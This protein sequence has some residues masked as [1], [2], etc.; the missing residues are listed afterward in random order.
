MRRTV[1]VVGAGA[2]SEFRLPLGTS[3]AEA[4]RISLDKDFGRDNRQDGTVAHA[5]ML[6][7]LRGEDIEGA[8]DL[9]GTLLNSPSIDHALNT[10]RDRP[11]VVR[12]G[13]VAIADQISLGE[14]GS[15]LPNGFTND[16]HLIHDCLAGSRHTWLAKLLRLILADRQ[17]EEYVDAFDDV[18]FV[19]FNYDRC[20]EQYLFY[21]MREIGNLSTQQAQAIIRE[22]PIVHVYGSL[23]L[24][25]C[26]GGQPYTDFGENDAHAVAAMSAGIKTYKEGA[27]NG[28][29]NAVREM[30]AAAEQVVFL[31]FGFDPTNVEVLYPD[32]GFSGQLVTG[33]MKVPRQVDTAFNEKLFG[34]RPP[35][36]TYAF[37]E[38]NC[39]EY[40]ETFG[41]GL[42]AD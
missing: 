31:G 40:I 2:S 13:K 22:I 33:T 38:V 1:F 8:R 32:G 7:V 11:S 29:L 26:L 9:R 41:A 28:T 16:R 15:P 18:S 36:G 39:A 25:A 42:T 14:K 23:G 21:A 4:I 37:Q 34:N 17:P 5:L 12:V 35:L 6:G 3:L 27:D 10:R 20:I 19:V 30:V 24:P